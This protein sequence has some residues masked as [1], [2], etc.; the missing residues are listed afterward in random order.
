MTHP[1]KFGHVYASTIW[2]TSVQGQKE[3]QVQIEPTFTDTDQPAICCSLIEVTGSPRWKRV[4]TSRKFTGVL[5][6]N[7]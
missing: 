4:A 6:D 1:D 3:W 5:R 2:V 7:V